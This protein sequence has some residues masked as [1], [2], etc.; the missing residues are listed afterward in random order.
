MSRGWSIRPRKKDASSN[1]DSYEDCVDMS[2]LLGGGSSIQ[3][4]LPIL[5]DTA[6]KGA[7]LIV[8]AAIAAYALRNRSAASRHA[9]WTAAVI[10][11]LAIPAL[12]FLPPSQD[13]DG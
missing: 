13:R 4:A 5:L 7:L 12:V 1:L 9:V 3:S 11:H 2:S 10:G 8:L 6:L